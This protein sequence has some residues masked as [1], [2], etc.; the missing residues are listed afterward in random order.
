MSSESAS[1]TV[2]YNV[3]T[4]TLSGVQMLVSATFWSSV[5]VVNC[6]SVHHKF[7]IAHAGCSARWFGG[8]VRCQEHA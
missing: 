8:E 3:P 4:L 6:P 5:I 7:I 2:T 1:V